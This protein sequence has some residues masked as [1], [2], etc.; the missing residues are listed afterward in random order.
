MSG[1]ATRRLNPFSGVLQV[2]QTASA[3]A[4]SDN[5]VVW[6]LQVMAAR[7]E[8]TWRSADQQ[9]QRELFNW[10]LWSP[11][12]GMYRVNANP[13]MDLGA[14]Q[15]AADELIHRLEAGLPELPFELTDRFEHWCCD[16]HGRPVALIG[17]A[18]DARYA[19]GSPD[20]TW[21]AT[22]PDEKGFESKTLASAGIPD[23]DGVLPRSH[24]QYL[25]NEV[26]HRAPLRIW[27]E[28][29]ADGSGRRLDA[30]QAPDIADFPTLGIE[31][32]WQ[33]S[34]VAG[35]VR[36]YIAWLSPLLLLLPLEHEHRT[37]LERLA[38]AQ[39]V[40]VAEHYRLYPE[41]VQPA[42]IE[43]ARVEARLRHA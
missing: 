2:V 26:H 8:H 10:A 18:I 21:H 7:P 40:Q 37:Q 11:E 32:H 28:R 13:L 43:Q 33:D 19:V 15:Q 12:R 6:R 41:I 25:E 39:A 1:Y 38:R 4:F 30:S 42:L 34:L 9:P 24:A 17:S 36:D 5:G 22:A 35:L 27:F 31:T 3:R 16:A 14:M 20:A 29:Q 23:N